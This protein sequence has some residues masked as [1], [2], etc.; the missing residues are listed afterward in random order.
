MSELGRIPRDVMAEFRV[1]L[2]TVMFLPYEEA[3]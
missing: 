3:L 2:R 1:T